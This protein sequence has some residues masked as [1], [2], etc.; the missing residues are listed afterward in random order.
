[1]IHQAGCVSLSGSEKC[2]VQIDVHSMYQQW[3]QHLKHSRN[4]FSGLG[5]MESG[6]SLRNHSC[7]FW[8]ICQRLALFSATHQAA[9]VISTG[10]PR[11]AQQQGKY[12]TTPRMCIL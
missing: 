4:E 3:N 7:D 11:D 6:F 10:T 9:P 1:M 8:S 2:D 5:R 12:R